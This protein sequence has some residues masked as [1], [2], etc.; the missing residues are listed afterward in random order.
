M[1]ID[2]AIGYALGDQKSTI[3]TNREQ[4]VARLVADGLTD[5]EIGAHL[6]ISDRTAENHVQ[7]VRNKLGL[8]S[9]SQIA[10]WFAE[11]ASPAS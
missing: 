3:L 8:R 9:R 7:R 2:L 5:K 1:R 11:R 4:T 6:R 10:R